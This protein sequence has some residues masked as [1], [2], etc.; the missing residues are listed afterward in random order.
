MDSS[1]LAS[2]D[3]IEAG[4][5]TLVLVTRGDLVGELFTSFDSLLFTGAGLLAEVPDSDIDVS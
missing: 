1:N 5:T 4:E 2:S 3:P